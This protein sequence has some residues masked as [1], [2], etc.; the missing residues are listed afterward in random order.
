M[1]C[2]RGGLQNAKL[3]KM[4]IK[5]FADGPIKK[6]CVDNWGRTALGSA[7]KQAHAELQESM[8]Q[9]SRDHQAVKQKAAMAQVKIV[10]KGLMKGA[11]CGMLHQWKTSADAAKQTKQA[12]H[13]RGLQQGLEQQLAAALETRAAAEQLVARLRQEADGLNQGLIDKA[14]EAAGQTITMNKDNG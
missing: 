6:Q 9:Q 4:I 12:E 11:Q 8:E 5:L 10:M 7:N 2:C 3:K 1:V 13:Q 14:D